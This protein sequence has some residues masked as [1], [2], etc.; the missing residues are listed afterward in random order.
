MRHPS[1]SLVLL[2][3]LY[4][5]DYLLWEVGVALEVEDYDFAILAG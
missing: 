2:L 4:P 5:L 3:Q 1:H